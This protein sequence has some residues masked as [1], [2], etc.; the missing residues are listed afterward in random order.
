MSN[1]NG[2]TYSQ[3]AAALD[4]ATSDPERLR[5]RKDLMATFGPKVDVN[6]GRR[7]SYTVSPRGYVFACGKESFSD[8]LFLG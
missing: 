8:V 2:M 3:F 7:N 5:I 4:A 6:P 1:T